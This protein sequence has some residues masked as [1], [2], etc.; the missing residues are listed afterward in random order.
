MDIKAKRTTIYFDPQLHRA[1]RMKAA[2]TN[3]SI[4]ELVNESVRYS[5]TE[6]ME[7]N[8]AFEQRTT[9]P[10]LSFED[11]LKELQRSGKI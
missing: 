1:L 3:R 7:D 9:E 8:M 6:D 4:S 5:L 2:Y 11:V 10:D